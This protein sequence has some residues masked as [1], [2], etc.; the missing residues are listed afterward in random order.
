MFDFDDER[1]SGDYTGS[2]IEDRGS[3]IED[4]RSRHYALCDSRS[5]IFYHRGFQP[6]AGLSMWPPNFWRIAE[7]VFSA[8]ELSWRER[9]RVKSETAST[10]T[11]T[12]SSI[13]AWI[14]QRPS[15]ESWTKP[16]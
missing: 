1:G 11:G 7:S 12:A 6:P 13:A 2:R 9:K 16:E 4:R 8:K 3:R 14:V 5:S 15:P 10:S